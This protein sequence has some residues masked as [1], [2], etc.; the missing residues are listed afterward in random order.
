MKTIDKNSRLPLYYQL[1]DLLIEQI[2]SKAVSPGDK[3]LSERELCEKYDVSRSTVRLAIQEMAREGYIEKQHGKGTFV[4]SER[5]KQDLLKFYSFTDE[6]KKIG[7]VPSSQVID[8]KTTQLDV[9]LAKKLEMSEGDEAYQFTRLRLA[10][11][12]PMMLETTYLP[13]S[14]FSGLTRLDLE[15]TALYELMCQRYGANFTLAEETFRP[16][17]LNE[18]EAKYLKTEVA[19]PSLMI[20][21]STYDGALLVEYTVGVTRGDCFKYSVILKK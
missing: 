3:L 13:K 21:R 11:G 18:L 1:M 15:Q 8:F 6:M 20:E 19:S 14:R 2:E 10:D 17:L 7:K 4:S 12:E 16:V 9:R 5:L